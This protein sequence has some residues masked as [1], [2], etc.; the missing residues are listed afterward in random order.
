M[1]ADP[2]QTPNPNSS[3]E[4]RVQVRVGMRVMSMRH[5]SK[6]PA[7]PAQ[8]HLHPRKI[9]LKSSLTNSAHTPQAKTRYATLVPALSPSPVTLHTEIE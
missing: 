5:I 8:E 3:T 1:S 7:D 2:T 9:P 6:A 4:R